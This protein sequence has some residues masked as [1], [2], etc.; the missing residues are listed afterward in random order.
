[1]VSSGIKRGAAVAALM[2]IA[3]LVAAC[4]GATT[5]AAPATQA[6]AATT[7]PAATEAPAATAAP[8][9]ATSAPAAESTQPAPEGAT[10]GGAL[11][12]TWEGSI[13]IAGQEIA[14]RFNI[15]TDG[16]TV[17]F[18]TQGAVGLPM[19]NFKAEGAAV[20]FEVL[21]APQTASFSGEAQG[22]TLSG[23][24]KQSGFEGTFSTTRGS[25]A[26]APDYGGE[27]VTF[28]NGDVTLAGTLTLPEGEGP[29]PAVVLISGS[30]AQNRDEEIFGFRPFAILAEELSNAGIAV[31]RYDDRGIGGSS[32]GTAD[33]TSETF[34][35]DVEAAIAFLKT[36]PEIDGAKIGLMG[37]S[38]G[39]IIAPI[40]AVETGDPAFLILLAGSS[41][42]GDDLLVEQAVAV[43]AANGASDAELASTREQQRAVVDAVVSG[44]G[45]EQL[46][47][48][49]VRQYR[50]AAEKLPAQQKQ[51]LGDLDQ[52]AE[53]TVGAQFAQ[54][55]SAWMKFFL[56]HD[57]APTL[58]KVT[59]PVLALFG[60]KDVQVPPAANVDALKA[61]LE[62]AGNED[63][64]VSVIP[65]A[66]HLFQA[67]DTGSPNEYTTLPKEFAPGVIETIVDW[68]NERVK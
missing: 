28:K 7:A 31:L 14:T 4:G 18:P 19:Q 6:P 52:R 49:M 35:G 34:A 65:G 29:H 59:V 63:V 22:E 30:G 5:P 37:H 13:K 53:A 44:E 51:A 32:A 58:E 8:D 61:A 39:G 45:L 21:P 60:E 48:D 40:V 66:N 50:E 38:E 67:A 36:R 27:D 64:S 12:G 62:K 54:L 16:G 46:R 56:T 20:S 11:V 26:A 3:A 57:P 25:A 1:M 9:A 23:V 2:V 15:A 55:E 33:D 42:P 41:I 68:L 43:N 17:D 47:A 24:F 10:G